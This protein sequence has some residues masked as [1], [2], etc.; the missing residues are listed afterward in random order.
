[1]ARGVKDLADELL[2]HSKNYPIAIIE[3]RD[4]NHGRAPACAR[5]SSYAEM[6]AIPLVY[7]SKGDGVIE[8]KQEIAS[9][10][11]ALLAEC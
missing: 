2:F 3:A 6:L 10:Q 4:N 11:T 1:M 5:A 8:H 7:R 9:S